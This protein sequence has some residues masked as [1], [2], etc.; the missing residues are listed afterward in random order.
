[1]LRIVIRLDYVP[2]MKEILLTQLASGEDD[3]ISAVIERLDACE[4]SREDL[5]EA[6]E[7]FKFPGIKRHSYADL[8]S[9]AKASFT[10]SYNK[11]T[12]TAQALVELALT[13]GKKTRATVSAPQNEELPIPSDA[14]TDESD[15]PNED[16]ADLSKF[17]RNIKKR[18]AAK[19][20]PKSNR[21][22][23]QKRN[24]KSNTKRV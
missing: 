17:M 13:S 9:K 8:D 16:D 11:T 19:A 21:R 18:K 3:C 1:M 5:T 23:G 22:S 7:S 10:R 14:E 24:A 15:D 20:D 4:I 6:M 2:Y 12:H